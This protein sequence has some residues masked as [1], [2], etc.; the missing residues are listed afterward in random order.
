MSNDFL[1]DG[2]AL[3]ISS[4]GISEEDQ[5]QIPAGSFSA[6]IPMKA[7]PPVV[8]VDVLEK[9]FT[10][11]ASTEGSHVEFQGSCG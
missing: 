7:F 9:A 6:E 4:S 2:I 10:T 11:E 8:V 1:T 5:N 3:A